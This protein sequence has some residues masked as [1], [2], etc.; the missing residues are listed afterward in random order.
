[1]SCGGGG[2]LLHCMIACRL[3]HIVTRGAH[4]HFIAQGKVADVLAAPS[5]KCLQRCREFGCAQEPAGR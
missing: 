2:E 3:V 5:A 4:C 1:M